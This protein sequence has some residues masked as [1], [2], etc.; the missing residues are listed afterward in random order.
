MLPSL[1]W[2]TAVL[3]AILL[4]RTLL[5][6]SL[7]GVLTAAGTAD[8]SP[9]PRRPSRHDIGLS[10]GSS[11]VF[12]LGGALVIQADRQ[13]LTRL[14]DGPGGPW[15]LAPLGFAGVLLL[16]DSLFY[17]V[18]RLL[19][20]RLLYAW[21][22]QGHHHSRQPTAWTAFAF[23]PGEA[24]LQ[25]GFLVAVALLLPLQRG[26]YLALL[27]SMSLWAVLNHLDPTRLPAGFRHPWL[28]RWLIGPGHHGHH[29]L[30]PGCNYGLYFTFWDRLCGTEARIRSDEQSAAP[31]AERPGGSR[32]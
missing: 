13:G 1:V 16:Q 7:A 2:F 12:A 30:R 15:W 5:L 20:H 32:H 31:A 22:H 10:L 21:M 23:D 28:G 6:T 19:H 25:A 27:L 11:W 9:P 3:Y 4:A 8:N 14:I 24:L 18:H 26:T 17:G 29:H